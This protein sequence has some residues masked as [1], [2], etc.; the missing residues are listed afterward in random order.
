MDLLAFISA[1]A[2]LHE[3]SKKKALEGDELK[4]YRT[5]KDELARAMIA[6]QQIQLKPG[7]T[8]LEAMRVPRVLQVDLDFSWGRERVATLDIGR[9]GFA[10]FI[11][12]QP[13]HAEAVG[14]TLKIPE[15]IDPMIGRCTVADVQ[16]YHGHLRTTFVFQDPNPQDLDKMERL[17]FDSL[18]E[19][20]HR[21]KPP[22]ARR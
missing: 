3:K 7:Q 18:I 19:Q 12:K 15:R 1:F 22:A 4:T 16:P 20:F 8:P 13:P 21:A 5:G 2:D 17:L 11:E 9:S 14:Y 6:A 10:T